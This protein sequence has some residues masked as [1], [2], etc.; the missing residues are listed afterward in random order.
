LFGSPWQTFIYCIETV[1]VMGGEKVVMLVFFLLYILWT[2][3][4]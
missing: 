2:E 4:V 3:G 1:E